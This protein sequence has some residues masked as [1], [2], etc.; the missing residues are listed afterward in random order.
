MSIPRRY[1]AQVREIWTMQYFF[2]RRRSRQ[3]YRLLENRKFR[4]GYDFLLL[5]ASVG[6]ASEELSDWWTRLQEVDE[7]ER[8]SMIAAIGGGGSKKR[9]RRRPRK[10][11]SAHT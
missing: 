5:R 8:R 6:Q 4:A 1:T 2:D 11:K 10:R 7:N 9:R 3:V